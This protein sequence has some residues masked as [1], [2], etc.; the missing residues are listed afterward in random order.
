ME[1]IED[2][3]ATRAIITDCLDIERNVI[4]LVRRGLLQTGSYLGDLLLHGGGKEI[5]TNQEAAM[6][7]TSPSPAS[8]SSHWAADWRERARRSRHEE[9]GETAALPE[10]ANSRATETEKEERRR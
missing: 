10:T 2:G 9:E 7:A 1:P 6:N 8:E 5:A 3:V 4:E